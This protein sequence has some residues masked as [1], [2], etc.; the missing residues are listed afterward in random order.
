MELRKLDLGTGATA[1]SLID[2]ALLEGFVGGSGLA[3]S[4]LAGADLSL[5]PLDPGL[6]LIVTVGA[7]TATGFPG[8][9]RACFTG[10]SALTGLTASSWLGGDFGTA[11]ARSGTLALVLEGK[12]PEPSIVVLT[13]QGA[14]LVPR[15]DLWG[16]TISQTRAALAEEYGNLRA[17]AIGPAGER[18]VPM[19]NIR[20]DE[21]HSA[22]RCG[23]GAVM[24]SKNIKA[25]VAQGSAKIPVADPEA[26]KVVSSEARQAINESPFLQEVQGPLSTPHL[27][28]PVN[29]FHAFPTG[30]H[31]ERF[32]ETAS[33]IYGERI[34]E[35]YVFKRTTCPYCS[36]RCRLHVRIDG[37]EFEAA[38]YETVW[39]F[40]GDNRVDD[41]ALIV[42]ANELCN[43]LGVD[44][45]STGNTVAFYRE[46]TDTMDD[47]SN[48]LDLVSR[49]GYREGVGDILARG[50]RAAAQEFGVDYAMQ[51]K[52]LEMAAYDPR[53]LTG[54]GL[55]YST[56]NRGGCHSRAWTVADELSGQEF[57]AAELAEKVASYHNAGC[58][59]DS[60]ITCTFLDGTLQPFYARAL[61]AVLGRTY[62]DEDLALIG[63]RVYTLERLLNVK[64]GV[65]AADDV[66]PRRILEGMVEPEKYRDGM[67][68]YYQI[69]DWD[70][71]GRP[72]SDKISALGLEFA[73]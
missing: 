32:F 29:E 26:L 65:G 64:R 34:A 24:G 54:M 50:T 53:K 62:T 45:I 59:R 11:F 67:E 46:Y 25:I 39:S 10:V 16:M 3:A 38:E 35:E 58:L 56:A 71:E 72:S 17:A 31:Q 42:R 12:A 13:E 70:A 41:Y 2:R 30:N 36:V 73:A 47:P 27:V 44:T 49:I 6:P 9:N 8:A 63:E 19:A 51:V 33:K 57:S 61:T 69:R 5:P 21:S 40:G 60:L 14:T 37:Q 52:G 15:P 55:S 4:L 20:G 28:A 66:L 7:L 43:E 22:G 68:I 1:N 48:V 23:L 18:L